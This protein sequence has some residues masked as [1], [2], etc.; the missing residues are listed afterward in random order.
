MKNF[1]IKLE[2]NGKIIILKEEGYTFKEAM[3]KAITRISA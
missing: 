3:D 2:A 1:I